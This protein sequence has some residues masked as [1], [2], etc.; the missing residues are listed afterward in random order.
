MFFM[1][2]GG[3]GGLFGMTFGHQYMQIVIVWL[4]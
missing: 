2:S 3:L 1:L 4:Q